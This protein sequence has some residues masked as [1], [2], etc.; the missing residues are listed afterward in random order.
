MNSRT[1]V[2]LLLLLAL[3][4]SEAPDVDPAADPALTPAPTTWDITVDGEPAD[5][6]DE[7]APAEGQV[8]QLGGYRIALGPPGEYRFRTEGEEL[9]LLQE[10]GDWRRVGVAV[11]LVKQG[12]DYVVDNPLAEMSLGEV[13]HLLS[14]DVHKPFDGLAA[15]LAAVDPERCVVR[16]WLSE[17]DDWKRFPDLPAGL[18]YLSIWLSHEEGDEYGNPLPDLSALGRLTALRW[19]E[20]YADQTR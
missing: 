5:F 19:L 8:T 10:S 9:H 12:D 15:K 17:L 11:Q 16:L 18:R 6:E 2:L 7:P 1:C 20:V 3:G 14:L 13:R 4:C